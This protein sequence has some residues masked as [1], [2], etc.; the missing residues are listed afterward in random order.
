MNGEMGSPQ[1]E[2]DICVHIEIHIVIP[3][4]LAQCCKAVILQL[5]N[6]S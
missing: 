6:K 2:R 4:K 5:K 3:Q 1:E